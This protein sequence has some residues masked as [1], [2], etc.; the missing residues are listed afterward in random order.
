MNEHE[1]IERRYIVKM[2]DPDIMSGPGTKIWQAYN[3]NR[4]GQR[5]R[6]AKPENQWPYSEITTKTGT[7]LKR[8]ETNAGINL[9]SAAA[10]FLW[11]PFKIQKTRYR[12]KGWE[13]D[14]FGGP[15]RGLVIAEFEMAAPDQRI[16]QPAWI[17]YMTEVTDTIDSHML[18]RISADPTR[19]DRSIPIYD[20]VLSQ[21]K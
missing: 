1:E 20:W 17:Y 7:G 11:W 19:I 13:I 12:R 16:Q 5:V 3:P 4:D 15:L 9:A 2:I 14:F 8:I 10:R 18:A 6:I 21:A